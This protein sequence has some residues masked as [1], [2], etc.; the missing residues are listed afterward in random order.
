MADA[1]KSMREQL[2]EARDQIRH[3]IE[4]LEAGPAYIPTPELS[5]GHID[6]AGRL[7]GVL[8]KIEAALADLGPED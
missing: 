3:Q 7:K 5:E 6:F 1:D 4:L 2:I 8:A